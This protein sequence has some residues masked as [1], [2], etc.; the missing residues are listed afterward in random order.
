[1]IFPFSVY[2][3]LYSYFISPVP[4]DSTHYELYS[5]GFLSTLNFS[6][7][8][9]YKLW[10]HLR[11]PFS[12]ISTC[13]SPN[14]P[15]RPSSNPTSS[16]K[17]TQISLCRTKLLQSTLAVTAFYLQHFYCNEQFVFWLRINLCL[18]L[19][20]KCKLLVCINHI[21]FI[22]TSKHQIQHYEHNS[23]STSICW[24]ESKRNI[25]L[26]IK[27]ALLVRRKPCMCFIALINLWDS[28]KHEVNDTAPK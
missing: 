27:A 25:K 2:P 26:I 9:L 14:P 22:Y 21:L 18:S 19:T 13:C 16:K 4:P 1:M 10:S 24:F 3:V 28:P 5:S 8:P 12:S 7:L 20:L 11:L 6:F 17:L 15:E 23:F